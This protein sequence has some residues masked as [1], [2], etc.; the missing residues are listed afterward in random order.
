MQTRIRRKR[1]LMGEMNVVPYIDVMLVLLIIFMVTAP[2]LTQGIDV[3]LP[4]VNSSSLDLSLLA[5]NEPLIL[6][7]DDQGNFYLNT[8]ANPDEPLN[9]EE[10]M[11]QVQIISQLNPQTPILVKADER[12]AYGRVVVGMSLLQRGGANRIGFLTEPP[13]QVN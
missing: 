6:S 12:V 2:M 1:T 7:V 3:D 9:D 11:R 8:G 10:I 5:E 13:N 4:N